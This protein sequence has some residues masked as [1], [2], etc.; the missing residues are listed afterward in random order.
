MLDGR[1]TGGMS[2]APRSRRR[3]ARTPRRTASRAASSAAIVVRRSPFHGLGVFTTAPVAAGTRVLEYT[4]ERISHAEAAARYYDGRS[5]RPHVLLF[6]VDRGTVIDG[7]TGDGY[8]R[9]VNHS[10]DPNCATVTVRGRVFIETLREVPAGVEL[11]Y[12]Y[13]LTRPQ[14]LPRDWRRR[15]PCR[16]GAARCRGTMLARPPR[17]RPP[18]PRR[19]PAAAQ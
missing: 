2:V 12:D 6:T 3:P 8:G 16:C 1:A 15:Y 13:R 18:R 5:P 9:Y 19:A 11:T 14:P 10:C 7:A 17:R 4:G